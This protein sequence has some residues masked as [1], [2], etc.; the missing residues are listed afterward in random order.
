MSASKPFHG[1]EWDVWRCLLQ[2]L[3]RVD[4]LMFPKNRMRVSISFS[5]NGKPKH[6]VGNGRSLARYVPLL[7]YCMYSTWKYSSPFR[8]RN[9]VRQESSL[10]VTRPPPVAVLCLHLCNKFTTRPTLPLCGTE[11]NFRGTKDSYTCR[12]K[13][14]NI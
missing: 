10:G 8:R 1:R 5:K 14:V 2:R 12:Q 9:Y 11:S 7:H 13:A 6:S 4:F 3:V